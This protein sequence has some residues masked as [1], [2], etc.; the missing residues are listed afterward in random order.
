VNILTLVTAVSH[1]SVICRRVALP[2]SFLTPHII[3]IT[4][5]AVAAIFVTL[6]ILPGTEM[7]RLGQVKCRFVWFETARHYLLYTGE[8]FTLHPSAGCQRLNHKYMILP[9]TSTGRIPTITF[10]DIGTKT[11]S[12][13]H[14]HTS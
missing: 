11:H 8:I 13:K 3:T 4:G 9:I 5:L 2:F 7:P 14:F 10:L 12:N 1:V 6:H